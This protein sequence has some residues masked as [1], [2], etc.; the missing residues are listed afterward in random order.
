MTTIRQA[1]VLPPGTEPL[2]YDHDE[3]IARIDR[4]AKLMDSEFKVPGVPLRFGLDTIVGLVPGV[5]DAVT[6]AVSL[7]LVNE[8]RKA[9]APKHLVA[10]MIANAAIDTAVGAIPV[11]GDVFDFAFKSN[12]KNARL[13]KRHLE[14]KRGFTTRVSIS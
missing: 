12:R 9:G 7:Y 1:E 14:K 6:G 8:A 2:Q 5:G 11:A 10:R 13:L 4:I 3:A